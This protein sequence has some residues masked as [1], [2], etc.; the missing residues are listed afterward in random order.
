[1][2]VLQMPRVADPIPESAALLSVDGDPP[3][4]AAVD[5]TRADCALLD[6]IVNEMDA[7]AELVSEVPDRDFV[8]TL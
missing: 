4:S 6:P 5:L 7:H 2:T 3:R 1:M 8:G